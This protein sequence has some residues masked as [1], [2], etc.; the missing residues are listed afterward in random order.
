MRRPMVGHETRLQVSISAFFALLI[1]PA[2]GATI[3][4]SYHENVRN[5]TELS[6][7][8]INRARD[9]AIAMAN[10]LLRPVESALR[11]TAAA[12]N[13]KPGFFRADESADLLYQ[14][15]TSAPQIDAV[16]V[17]FEDG[18]HRVVTRMD[19][20]RRRTD[21]RIPPRANWHMSYIDAFGP[22]VHRERHRFFYER[23]PTVIG[24]FSV[25]ASSFDVRL[26]VPQ[27]QLS[28][29]SGTLSVT[30]P[31]INP[32]TGAP[33]IALGYPIRVAD[34]FVGVASAHITLD[35]LSELLAAHRA[36]ANSITVITD[37]Y[38][39][40]LGHSV[41]GT[42]VSHDGGQARLVSV[43]KLHDPQVV[44]AIQL[45]N[46]GRPDRFSFE[47]P[48]THKDYVALFSELPA[49]S[50]KEWR[51]LVVTPMNDFIGELNRTNR[52]LIWAAVVL[53]LVEGGLIYIM[54]RRISAPIVAVS[55]AIQRIR[56]LSFG[57]ELP[58]GSRIREVAQLQ[59]ATGLL[60]SAL[61]SFSLFAPVGIVRELI[62][63]G[64][65]VAPFVEQ[66]FMTILFSDV[67]GFTS[68]A[69]KLS[70]QELSEQTSRY[71]E[72][73]TSA[74]SQEGGTVD[75]FIGDSVMAFWGA[76]AA[77]EN[78]AFKACVAA[79]RAQHRM[80]HLNARWIAEGKKPMRVRIGIHCA[81]VVVGNVGSPERLN[82]TAM[83]DGVNV[84]SRIE[85][86]NK[87]FGSSICISQDVQMQV[88]S[89]VVSRPLGQISVRGRESEIKVYELLA[90][91]GSD[92][93]ELSHELD[94]GNG[95]GPVRSA[96][97]THGAA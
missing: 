59:R 1:L 88:G 23:W 21:S 62:E 60:A 87:Q 85:G 69:E 64:R 73:V 80:S 51:V 91:A 75:K 28:K 82:Y 20:D 97:A 40:V 30:D 68:I 18:F 8:F 58:T 47:L 86:L 48:S 57:G 54:A 2:L 45:H 63:S 65:P 52:L 22:G 36:S 32:D 78:Q 71:F 77:A 26:L 67:E 27:Y 38:G 61:R 25:D 81:D 94:R 35:T 56:T 3:A 14:V 17:S 5:L 70:P 96:P 31:F 83:G 15:L 10:G 7:R 11:L 50:A 89:S 44:E 12:E 19:A 79:L 43:E 53:T 34:K 66:R 24:E 39:R 46:S 93:P 92:D 55:D 42:A 29:Q 41:P 72:L 16:Y 84:A 4:F 74:V 9:D 49:G 33:V 13:I 95:S 6:Q 76:P 37:Q 90:I